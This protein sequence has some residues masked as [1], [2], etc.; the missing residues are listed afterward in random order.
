M[1][2]VPGIVVE[3]D[4]EIHSYTHACILNNRMILYD[5]DERIVITNV[6]EMHHVINAMYDNKIAKLHYTR[7][8]TSPYPFDDGNWKNALGICYT[9][10][11]EH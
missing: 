1:I 2:G 4:G 8:E 6:N 3:I 11:K 9:N 5:R 7:V 10:A